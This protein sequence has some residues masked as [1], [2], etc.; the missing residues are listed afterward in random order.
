MNDHF[1]QLGKL[2]KIPKLLKLPYCFSYS[3][4]NGCVVLGKKTQNTQTLGKEVIVY[5]AQLPNCL[6]YFWRIKNG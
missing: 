2:G 6:N 5:S 4:Q 1:R 3:S